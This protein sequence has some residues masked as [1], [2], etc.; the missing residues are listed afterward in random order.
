MNKNVFESIYNLAEANR[1]SEDKLSQE[2][3]M[4]MWHNGTRGFNIEAASTSKLRKNLKICKSKGYKAEAAKIRNEIKKRGLKVDLDES[5]V[6][7]EMR[8]K[9]GHWISEPGDSDYT[10]SYEL[11]DD[12][13]GGRGGIVFYFDKDK[14]LIY[15][16]ATSVWADKKWEK[17]TAVQTAW[18]SLPN[19]HGACDAVAYKHKTYQDLA[20]IILENTKK[21]YGLNKLWS[22]ANNGDNS[23]LLCGYSD[24]KTKIPLEKLEKGFFDNQQE[25]FDVIDDVY[26]D[27]NTG[28][29]FYTTKEDSMSKDDLY[30]LAFS[31]GYQDGLD[32]DKIQLSN[33]KRNCADSGYDF[34]TYRKGYDAGFKE[35]RKDKESGEWDSHQ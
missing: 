26:E 14:K 15:A 9:N 19:N 22:W 1:I 25:S 12:E 27:P 4:D 23:I 35:G 3:K 31:D 5:E 33:M 34:E 32:D 30:N 28:D 24:F 8:M 2:E 11:P 7:S 16:I 20:K 18:N 17:K 21:S 10:G 13:E 29:V 6:L